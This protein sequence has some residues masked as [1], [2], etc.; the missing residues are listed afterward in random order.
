MESGGP[1]CQPVNTNSAGVL[2][3]G[4]H[5]VHDQPGDETTNNSHAEGHK[6]GKKLA[7]GL[8]KPIRKNWQN[9]PNL[10]MLVLHIYQ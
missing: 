10:T 6:D 3:S 1:P 7:N 2:G 9:Q 5:L 4:G 8:K